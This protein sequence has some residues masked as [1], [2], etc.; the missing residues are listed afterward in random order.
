MN[1]RIALAALPLVV[2]LGLAA[3]LF[4]RLGAG[5]ASKLPSAIGWISKL[6]VRPWFPED[7]LNLIIRL[8]NFRRTPVYPPFVH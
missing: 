5:D 1:R 2:F 6:G 7:N 4:V 3:L 8:K